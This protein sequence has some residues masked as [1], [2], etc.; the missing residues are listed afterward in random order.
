MKTPDYFTLFGLEPRLSLDAFDLEQRF[1]TL[2]RK[3]HPDRFVRATPAEREQSVQASA[4][5]NEAY[6]TLSNPIARV[7]YVLRREGIA[8]PESNDVPPDLLSEVFELNEALDEVK[9]GHEEAR[10]QLEA[11]WRRF[12]TLLT[13]ADADIDT[14]SM[15]YDRGDRTALGELRALLTRRRF[16]AKTLSQ[17]DGVLVP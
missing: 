2:S 7:E 15:R 4:V 14:L 10:P 8:D 13:E 16:L 17:M 11:A 12:L 1:Y 5:L 3:L 6:R 9:A